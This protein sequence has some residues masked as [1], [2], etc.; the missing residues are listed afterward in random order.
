MNYRDLS[1]S[2]GTKSYQSSRHLITLSRVPR[3]P[4]IS[5]KPNHTREK[6]THHL[7]V[8]ARPL[9]YND[10]QL[11]PPTERLSRFLPNKT[12]SAIGPRTFFRL[13]GRPPHDISGHDRYSHTP[14]EEDSPSRNRDFTLRDAPLLLLAASGYIRV[15]RCA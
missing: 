9:R 15:Y 8:K 4:I 2:I 1:I 13:A 12:V 7:P 6:K 10:I 5:T 3:Q 14:E 11:P